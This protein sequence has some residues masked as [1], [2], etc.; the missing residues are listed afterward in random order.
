MIS[1][2]V[3]VE[4]GPRR[5]S[6]RA[7]ARPAFIRRH[8]DVMIHKILSQ[9]S[10]LRGKH[11]VVL[12][13]EGGLVA[14]IASVNW[15]NVATSISL[16]VTTLVAGFLTTRQLIRADRKR[17]EIE[18]K[19]SLTHQIEELNEKLRRAT[20]LDRQRNQRIAIVQRQNDRMTEQMGELS[21]LLMEANKNSQE[22]TIQNQELMRQLSRHQQLTREAGHRTADQMAGAVSQVQVAVADAVDRVQEATGVLKDEIRENREAVIKVADATGVPINPPLPEGPKDADAT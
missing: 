14:W 4:V 19:E 1:V 11:Y 13:A 6:L 22:L 2:I 10:A 16:F 12:I 18:N 5:V 9:L 7:G 21:T 15:Q 3:G 17:Y 8:R 20:E